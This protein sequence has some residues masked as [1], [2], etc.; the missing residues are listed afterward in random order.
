VNF[1]FVSFDSLKESSSHSRAVAGGMSSVPK[2]VQ[3]AWVLQGA[4]N[5]VNSLQPFGKPWNSGQ[6]RHS[7]TSE[8]SQDHRD[9]QETR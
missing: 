2:P 7:C 4:R 5:C 1:V 3:T 9:R 8:R 6:I